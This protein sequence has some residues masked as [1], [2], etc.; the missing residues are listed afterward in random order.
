MTKILEDTVVVKDEETGKKTTPM[1]RE[2]GNIIQNLKKK[3]EMINFLEI[4][5]FTLFL[6]F[7]KQ[8]IL[9]QTLSYFQI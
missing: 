2:M 5:I 9:T 7:S 6:K 8:N 1:E 3:T 4:Y